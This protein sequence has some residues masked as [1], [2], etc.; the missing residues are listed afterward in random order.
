MIFPVV[1][2]SS[3]FI[4]LYGVY[5]SVGYEGD[6]P[7]AGCSLR[8][9]GFMSGF[10]DNLDYYFSFYYAGSNKDR[11]EPTEVSRMFMPFTAG[12]VYS[13]PVLYQPLLAEFSAG[14]GAAFL[15][16]EGPKMI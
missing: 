11:D 13:V 5:T 6:M 9:N 10:F 14:I 3:T 2:A 4:D 12:I 15:E 7:G 16:R 8:K 1:A